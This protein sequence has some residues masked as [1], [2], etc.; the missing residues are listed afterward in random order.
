MLDLPIELKS[1]ISSLQWLNAQQLKSQYPE[2]L[3][4]AMNCNRDE[5]MRSLVA[6]RLQERFYGIRLSE[7]TKKMLQKAV[8]GDKILRSS[9]EIR[10]PTKRKLIRNWKGIDYEVTIH[11]DGR[12]EFDGKLYRSLTAVAKAITGSHWNGPVF[13]GVKQ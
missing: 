12:I 5:L 3:S 7:A 1:E 4:D 9:A 8:E 6:Y 10:K 2:L 11:E 13:F